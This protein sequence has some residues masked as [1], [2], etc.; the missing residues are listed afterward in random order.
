MDGKRFLFLG[1][2]EFRYVDRYC[3]TLA[4]DSVIPQ[5]DEKSSYLGK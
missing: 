1:F 2:H 5:I 4:L 3:N